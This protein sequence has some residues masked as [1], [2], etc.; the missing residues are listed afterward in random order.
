M[1]PGVHTPPWQTSLLVQGL[2]VLQPCPFGAG[3]PGV[4][5]PPRH[6]STPLQALPSA[7]SGLVVQV[8]CAD[9][10]EAEARNQITRTRTRRTDCAP[11]P[12]RHTASLM[13]KQGACHFCAL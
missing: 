8:C 5:T 12:V 6:S 2:P 13:R 10:A 3:G 11:S 9:T 7:Q 4:H 1:V